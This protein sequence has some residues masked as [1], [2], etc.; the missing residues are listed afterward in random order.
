MRMEAVQKGNH[1]FLNSFFYVTVSAK[2]NDIT[3]RC[4]VSFACHE[5]RTMTQYFLFATYI[6]YYYRIESLFT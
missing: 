6:P 2:N 4:L 5:L 3:G 1:P